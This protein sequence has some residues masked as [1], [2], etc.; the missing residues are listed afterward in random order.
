MELSQ[1]RWRK[2]QTWTRA[3]IIGSLLSCTACSF[4]PRTAQPDAESIKNLPLIPR[5]LLFEGKVNFRPSL[6]P[7]GY[8]VAR[9]SRLS[10]L[11]SACFVDLAEGGQCQEIY[12]TNNLLR[13]I[14]WAAN[15]DLLLL[16]ET[17]VADRNEKLIAINLSNKNVVHVAS[18]SKI[19][20]VFV[21]EGTSDSVLA[22]VEDDKRSLQQVRLNLQSKA[23]QSEVIPNGMLTAY[24]DRQGKPIVGNRSNADGSVTW[25]GMANKQWNVLFKAALDDQVFLGT[26]LISL[27]ASEEFAYFLDSSGRDQRALVRY[28]LD[29]RD[30]E[31]VSKEKADITH[32]FADR[33]TGKPAIYYTNYLR[34][35]AHPLSGDASELLSKVSSHCNGVPELMDEA[36]SGA[37][38]VSCV[39]DR[40]PTKFFVFQKNENRVVPLDS[41]RPGLERLNFEKTIANTVL[42][43]DGTPLTTYLTYPSLSACKSPR[44]PMAVLIHGG[45]A[46]RDEW[47]FHP[48]VHMLSNRGYFVLRVNYRGSRGFGKQFEALGKKQ[49]GGA[50]ESDVRDATFWTLSNFHEIDSERIAV[51]GASYGGFAALNYAA[52]HRPPVRCGVSIAGSS[53]RASFVESMGRKNRALIE[54]PFGLLQSDGDPS[55]PVE[56]A[57]LIAW[58]PI[59]KIKRFDM[60]T[61]II[62]GDADEWAPIDEMTVF[63]E[64]LAQSGKPVSFQVL[65]DQGH[66]FSEAAINQV[67]GVVES[68]FSKCLGGQLERRESTSSKV[69][70]CSWKFIS[71]EMTNESSLCADSKASSKLNQ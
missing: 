9:I 51:M 34:P 53:D 25:F 52:E 12:T 55:I 22:I 62:H 10:P 70:P 18:F 68:F 16:V 54:G 47:A 30:N 39:S 17:A 59:S 38:L 2:W 37:V 26:K 66:S 57:R 42:A 41:A 45:P 27:S 65:H 58:S 23:A 5:G 35:T 32:A 44:C 61:L 64:Q 29:G 67:F 21:A 8:R 40:A 6:S 13:L 71:G 1:I 50:I 14:G 4:I 33:R 36:L 49:R 11:H 46:V 15:S 56:R 24:V 3:A 31:V 48:W 19:L 43:T 28:S 63:A 69:L 7:D 20:S 60:P